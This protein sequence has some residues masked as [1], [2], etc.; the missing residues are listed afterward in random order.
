ML[1]LF[2]CI[3]L[4]AFSTAANA[5]VLDMCTLDRDYKPL[6]MRDGTGVWQKTVKAAAKEAGI[7]IRFF[8]APRKR[9]LTEIKANT[10]DAIFSGPVSGRDKEMQFPKNSAGVLEEN[11]AVGRPIYRVYRRKGSA[12]DWD[13]KNFVGLG[14][15]AVGVQMGVY[16]MYLLKERGVR[17]ETPES[18]GQVLRQL[19]MGRIAAVVVNEEQ[20]PILRKEL[21]LEDVEALSAPFSTE[22]IFV[23]F[24][25]EFYKNHG[26]EAERF[27]KAIQKVK[28]TRQF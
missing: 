28:D 18:A 8:M 16:P 26:D 4:L 14:V 22:P 3:L 9:C 17:I 13:G 5:L 23:A 27:W 12:V 6:T 21:T 11:T 20:M 19:K 10:T 2:A 25:L 1:Q 7:K 15:D 24:S